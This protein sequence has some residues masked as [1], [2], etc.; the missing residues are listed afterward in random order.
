MDLVHAGSSQERLLVTK[1]PQFVWLVTTK[2]DFLLFL[3]IHMVKRR[4]CSTSPY[5]GSQHP[6]VSTSGALLAA[7]AGEGNLSGY[8]TSNSV[9]WPGRDTHHFCS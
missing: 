8:H 3:H 1:I 2:L 6:G 4:V 7:Q 9:L 5:S